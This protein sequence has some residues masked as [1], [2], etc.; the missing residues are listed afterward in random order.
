VSTSFVHLNVHSHFSLL[1][2]THSVDELVAAVRLAGMQALALTDTNGLYAA[3]DFQAACRVA[4]VKPV[5]GVELRHVG[6]RA[7]VLADGKR[8][9]AEDLGFVEA[10]APIGGYIAVTGEFALIPFVLGF[11]IMTWIAGLDIVYAL[12]D[13]DFD[14]TENLH[15]IP[16]RLGKKNALSLSAACY[17]F[18]LGAMIY[19]GI[20]AQKDLAY[21]IAL[22]IIGAIF[23]IQQ[24]LARSENIASAIKNF[25]K[26][27]MF[28]SPLLFFGTLIDLLLR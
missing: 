28:I 11:A 26:I 1:A 23:F 3:T 22:V 4:D 19:A 8:I 13:M 14:A 20:L 18:S 15:S 5:F 21:W 7:V 27:N 10:A 17:G 2:G 24:K 6:K 16:V 25:F 12:Q 9:T